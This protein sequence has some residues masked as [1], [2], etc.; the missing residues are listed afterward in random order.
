MKRTQIPILRFGRFSRWV[1]NCSA[2][3][4]KSVSQFA[5]RTY[6][7]SNLHLLKND[8]F[9]YVRIFHGCYRKLQKTSPRWKR[10]LWRIGLKLVCRFT[11]LWGFWRRIKVRLFLWIASLCSA[12]NMSAI[13]APAKPQP[14]LS[15]WQWFMA[16]KALWTDGSRTRFLLHSILTS[17]VPFKLL[18]CK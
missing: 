12:I 5:A 14:F 1:R 6:I 16:E 2:L 7:I 9:C 11:R 10:Q 3:R 13:D 8:N 17:R 18:Y 4:E 15:P